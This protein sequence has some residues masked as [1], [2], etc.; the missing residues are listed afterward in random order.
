V[1]DGVSAK[2][3]PTEEDLAR[4]RELGRTVARAVLAG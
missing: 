4:C 1:A 3:Q 2:W